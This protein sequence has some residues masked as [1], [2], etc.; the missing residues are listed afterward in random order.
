MLKT[1][2]TVIILKKC[3]NQYD[4]SNQISLAK[5]LKNKIKNGKN[6]NIVKYYDLKNLKILIFGKSIFLLWGQLRDS[7]T[8]IKKG[9]N[10]H[11][12]SRRK[13]ALRAGGANFWTGW[14]CPIF[15]YFVEISFF[16]FCLALQQKILACF[17]KYKL[18][19]IYL[20][21]QIK[22]VFIPQLL[23]HRVS[24]W[25]ISECVNLF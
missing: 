19:T 5:W 4:Q 20:D 23:M 11:W 14:R 9:S 21:I 7:N 24:F 15:C 2:T 17:P 22:K 1:Y 10:S 8:T 6:I 18:N 16:C 25:S 3:W 12:C 13:H